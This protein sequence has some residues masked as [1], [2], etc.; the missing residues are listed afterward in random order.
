MTIGNE[1]V[2]G[3]I[4]YRGYVEWTVDEDSLESLD[5]TCRPAKANEV[6]TIIFRNAGDDQDVIAFIGDMVK[7]YPDSSTPRTAISALANPTTDTWTA[8]AHGFKVGDAATVS[9]A[10]GGLTPGVI[11]YVITTAS[12]NT[13]QVS[14]L[15]EGTAANVADIETNNFTIAEEFVELTRET[16]VSFAAASTVLPVAGLKRVLVSGWP[17][18]KDTGRLYFAKATSATAT[19]FKVYVEI[20]KV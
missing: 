15:R 11:Y 7:C 8:A 14:A 1:D 18:R 2:S 20:R 17:M 3:A 4:L 16:V 13:F 5:I 10:T 6:Y 12:A 19:A 9:D